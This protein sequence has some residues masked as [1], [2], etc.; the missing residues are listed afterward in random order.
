[1]NVD[2]RRMIAEL[3]DRVRDVQNLDKDGDAE[4]FIHQSMRENPD[5]PYLLVQSV[6]AQ[7]VALQ[8]AGGRIGEVGCQAP[9]LLHIL[10]PH[11]QHG[12]N[13]IALGG[14]Q[15]AA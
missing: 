15:G 5:S 11:A 13:L 1:M 10:V 14:D 9:R 6:L 2:E 4:A 12:A 8:E 3:F 7:E